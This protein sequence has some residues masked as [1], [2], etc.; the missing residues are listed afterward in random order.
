VNRVLCRDG[1]RR[2]IG[3]VSCFILDQGPIFFA[4]AHVHDEPGPAQLVEITKAAAAQVRM[5]GIEPKVAFISASNFGTLDT[6]GA[7]RMREAVRLM[8]RETV[9]FEY[10]GEMHVDAAV[11]PSIRDRLFPDS[12]L[13]GPA[14]LLI[15]PSMDAASAMRNALKSLVGGL[16]V[17]PILMGLG[18]AAHVVTPSITA[19]GLLNVATLAAAGEFGVV[20]D[21]VPR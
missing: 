14:N 12:R 21:S 17:G 2:A 19:R 5:F 10:E 9:D 8:D 7:R 4:D 6:P 11:D 16:Q 18:G 15:M 13:T 20:A 1:R 3:T